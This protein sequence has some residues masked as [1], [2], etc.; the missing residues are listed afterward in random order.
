MMRESC[1]IQL[2]SPSGN[3]TAAYRNPQEWPPKLPPRPIPEGIKVLNNTE[4]PFRPGGFNRS[5]CRE[6]THGRA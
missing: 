4:N 5:H 2:V 3:P 6:L 1:L